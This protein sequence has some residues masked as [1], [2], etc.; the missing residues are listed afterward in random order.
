VRQSRR[1]GSRHGRPRRLPQAGAGLRILPY[2]LP[3]GTAPLVLGTATTLDADPSVDLPHLSKAGTGARVVTYAIAGFVRAQPVDQAGAPLG[4]GYTV[5]VGS[6]NVMASDVDGQ[7]TSFLLAH[8]TPTA[9]GVEITARMLTWNA[10]NQSLALASTGAL[11]NNTV[12]DRDPVVAL[13]GPK[14]VVAWTQTV[15]FLNTAVK[16][17][18]LATAGCTFCGNEV[19]LTGPQTSE[20]MPAIAGEYAGGE[21]TSPQALLVCQ[22]AT[23]L[24]PIV[25]DVTATNFT[26]APGVDTSTPLWS[27]CGDTITLSTVGP[28]A[29]GNS[30]FA[31]RVQTATTPALGLFLF[32]FSGQTLS[33]GSCTAVNPIVFGVKP[34]VAGGANYA[35]PLPCDS[36]FL[37]IGLEAQA[38]ALGSTTNACPLYPTLSLS[39]ARRFTIVE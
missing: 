5:A 18:P 15:G 35:L 1:H 21:P 37:G 33:C 9:N 16:A 3:I 11:T 26:V 7:G 36:G 12:A 22:S 24:P 27:G 30:T 23:Q 14:F 28:F 2:T 25:A 4:V 13:L 34:L 20:S 8:E 10:G 31:F 32:G 39:P 17:R 38:G 29:I 6:G 19:T